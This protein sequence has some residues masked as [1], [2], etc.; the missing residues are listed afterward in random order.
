MKQE[1]EKCGNYYT[2]KFLSKTLYFVHKSQLVLTLQ[3]FLAWISD[4]P[5]SRKDGYQSIKHYLVATN[6]CQYRFLSI[7]ITLRCN[8]TQ[9][10]TDVISLTRISGETYNLQVVSFPSYLV[11]KATVVVPG[12][13][14]VT[15]ETGNKNR[16]DFHG[17][18]M[19]LVMHEHVVYFWW[20]LRW[21]V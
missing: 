21:C 3:D 1:N 7:L 16:D 19:R 12:F 17:M 18:Q 4:I 5:S 6:F 20:S 2:Y 11:H 15:V 14:V 9:N 8:Y 13:Q 10:C